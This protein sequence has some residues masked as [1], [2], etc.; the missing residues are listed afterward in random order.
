MSERYV[1]WAGIGDMGPEDRPL[2]MYGFDGVARVWSVDGFL[3]IRIAGVTGPLCDLVAYRVYL[4]CTD[5]SDRFP[6]EVR[7][8]MRPIRIAD[9][10]YGPEDYPDHIESLIESVKADVMLV[11]R[12]TESIDD[13]R[14]IRG[15]M[16]KGVATFRSSVDGL[17]DRLPDDIRDSILRGISV[18]E[19]Y[20]RSLDYFL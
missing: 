15:L 3:F 19:S 14:H 9:A 4:G 1:I 11:G 17:G 12:M 6:M 5:V 18:A 16:G 2:D 8:L 20:L 7:R 10:D 13:M